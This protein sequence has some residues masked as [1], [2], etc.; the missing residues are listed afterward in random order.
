M[1]CVHM[2]SLNHKGLIPKSAFKRFNVKY[3]KLDIT[4][5]SKNSIK[6]VENRK[7][8]GLRWQNW[9]SYKQ[10]LKGRQ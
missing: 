1:N 7:Q 9:S 10:N 2:K 3:Y 4:N 8:Q 5:I 6:L